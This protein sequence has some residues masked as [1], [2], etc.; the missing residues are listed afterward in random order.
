MQ[1]RADLL[2]KNGMLGL[3]LVLISL[4]LF[5]EIRLA[6]WVA[7]GIAVSGLGA[8]AAML[9]L[10]IPINTISLFSFVLAIGIVVD[11]AIV[12]AEHIQ[13]E[14]KR[15]TPGVVAAV[16]G[17]R[18]IK[19]PL[20]FAVLTYGGG[21]HAAALHSL[22]E[23]VEIWAGTAGHHHHHAAGFSGRIAAGV[24]QPPVP[25]ARPGMGA[26]KCFRSVLHTAPRVVLNVAAEQVCARPPQSGA[27]VR[28]G[29]A[30]GND[31]GGCRNAYAKY[32]SVTGGYRPYHIG[33]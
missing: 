1:E 2:L 32:L 22:V 21:V 5:L 11:D 31:G 16:R 6:L 23:S 30:H 25:S 4:S 14:R 7:V 19:V 15:G 29:P 28:D 33:R 24:A 26:D 20:T 27:A 13:D 9:V 8:L 17:V 12:V 18:R 10:D 3:L